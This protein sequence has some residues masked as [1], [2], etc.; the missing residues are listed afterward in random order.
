M[1]HQNQV[2]NGNNGGFEMDPDPDMPIAM[3]ELTEEEND[4]VVHTIQCL[5][6]PVQSYLQTSHNT[7]NTANSHNS[8]YMDDTEWEEGIDEV[9]ND[10]QDGFYN[11]RVVQLLQRWLFLW[12]VLCMSYIKIEKYN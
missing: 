4:M 3:K 2:H 1:Q 8:Q 10:A 9:V 5:L 12:E 6:T 11:S 7:H